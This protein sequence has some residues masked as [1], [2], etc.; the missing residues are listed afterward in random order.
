[1]LKIW[2]GA[3]AGEVP[4][5]AVT[6]L[7]RR[8]LIA[9][10]AGATLLAGATLALSLAPGPLFA[11]AFTAADQLRELPRPTLGGAP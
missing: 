10:Y 9:R 11:L 2:F 7:P 4:A 5:T 3:F 1:M 8:E 6:V